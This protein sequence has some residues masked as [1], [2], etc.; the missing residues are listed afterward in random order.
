MAFSYTSV[1]VSDYS[2]EGV[3]HGEAYLV[4]GTWTAGG[5]ATGTIVTGGSRILAGGVTNS[6]VVSE[7]PMVVFNGTAGSM[8]ITPSD[9][10]NNTGD[11]WAIVI[12]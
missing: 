4:S 2:P 12:P 7:C 5:D 3:L 6:E 9:T 10:T 11:W 8:V 1:S